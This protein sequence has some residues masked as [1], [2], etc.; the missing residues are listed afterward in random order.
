M[1]TK[2]VLQQLSASEGE[3]A[4]RLDRE[5]T[6]LQLNVKS[7]FLKAFLLSHQREATKETTLLGQKRINFRGLTHIV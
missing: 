1:R 2:V 3:A 5:T 4:N 6:L 7:L